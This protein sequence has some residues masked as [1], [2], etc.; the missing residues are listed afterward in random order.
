MTALPPSPL[1]WETHPNTS[2]QGPSAQLPME[3]NRWNWG[4][5]FLHW[6]WAAVHKAWLG[7]VLCFLLGIIGS[8]I[9]G[10]KGNEWAWQNNRYDSVE[11]F[12]EI[13]RKWA[14]WGLAIQ[15]IPLAIVLLVYFILFVVAVVGA[16]SRLG[17]TP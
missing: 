17:A 6:I 3:L 15:G 5:F 10:V 12:N 13:Q 7:V 16:L 1:Y 11:Q 4:A 9:C 14:L 2:G 8:V